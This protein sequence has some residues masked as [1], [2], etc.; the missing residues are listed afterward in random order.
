VLP[1]QKKNKQNDQEM[2]EIS[3]KPSSDNYNFVK[4]GQHSV[5]MISHSILCRFA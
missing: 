2:G 3:L 5:L 1:S 4:L